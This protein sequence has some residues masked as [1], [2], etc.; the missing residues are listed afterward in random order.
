MENDK[1]TGIQ[2]T[3][4]PANREISIVDGG[5]KIYASEKPLNSSFVVDWGRVYVILDC[6]GSM[7][8]PKLD[9][10]KSG[11]VEFARD[12]FKKQYLVGLIKFSTR[13]DL[14]SEPA[15]EIEAIQIGLKGIRAG[16]STNLTAAVNLAQAKLKGFNGAK[17]MV[18]ATDGMPDNIKRS[19]EAA[20]IA[21]AGGIEI[22]TIGTDDA[23]LEYLKKL[24]SRTE[25]SSRVASEMFGKA[26][27]SASLLLMSPRSIQPR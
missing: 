2:I 18:I 9:L 25:L 20:A 7:K 15:P 23:D 26:I 21:K 1:R 8:G 27:S 10:A 12:A 19:L 16:G 14:M 3:Q 4:Q 11:I 24:A 17:A 6:S 13:A 5:I 22:I